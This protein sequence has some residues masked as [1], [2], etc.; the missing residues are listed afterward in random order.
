MNTQPIPPVDKVFAALANPLRRAVVQRLANGPAA[1]SELASLVDCSLPVMAKHLRCLEEA[2]LL[3]HAKRGRVRHCRLVRDPLGP[4]AAW[5]DL[6]RSG[7]RR[8]E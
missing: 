6:Y 4:A 1:V 3:T 7:A 8:G 2:G 5:L